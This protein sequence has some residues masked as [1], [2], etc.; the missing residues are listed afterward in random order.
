MFK[1]HVGPFLEA[2][3]AGAAGLPPASA[4]PA[5]E[6]TPAAEPATPAAGGTE[7]PFNFPADAV[8]KKRRARVNQTQRV[9]R[10]RFPKHTSLPCRKGLF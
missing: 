5:P 6:G 3:G 9:E 1:N 10:L 4:T 2:D 8:D 7:N